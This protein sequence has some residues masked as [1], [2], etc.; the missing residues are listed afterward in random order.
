MKRGVAAFV[1]VLFSFVSIL[2]HAQEFMEFVIVG[3]SWPEHKWGHLSLR[4][5]NQDRDEV[6]DFGRYGAM[7]GPWDSNGE[8]ILRVWKKATRAHLKYQKKGDPKIEIVNIPISSEESNAAFA[9]FDKLI[10][11]AKVRSVNKH[12]TE[13]KLKGP[14]FHVVNN[15]CVTVAMGAFYAVFPSLKNRGKRYARGDGLYFWARVKTNNVSYN[16]RNQ[17]WN[18]LWWPQDVLNFLEAEIISTRRGG[19]SSY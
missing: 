16:K 15:N 11:D 6:F 17:C 8:P 12:L 13:Y 7:W 18:H 1:F 9:H 5:K 3:K 10:Q 19:T 4:I 2:V 14:E